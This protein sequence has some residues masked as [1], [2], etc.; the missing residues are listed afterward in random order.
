MATV[1]HLGLFPWCLY[2]NKDAVKKE[3]GLTEDNYQFNLN[4]FEGFSAPINVAVKMYW[5]VRKWKAEG[6]FDFAGPSNQVVKV[7]Y[8]YTYFREA[9][10]EK[11]LV[12]GAKQLIRQEELITYSHPDYTAPL[13]MGS[14]VFDIA[15]PQFPVALD[16]AGMPDPLNP[17]NLFVWQYA[18]FAGSEEQGISGLIDT[19][20]QL[21]VSPSNILS[22]YKLKAFE[23]TYEIPVFKITSLDSSLTVTAL[24]Y[25]PYD[26]EDGGGPI[27]D[28]LTGKQIRAFPS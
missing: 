27:Y 3:F 8:T 26:P 6:S 7:D 14:A 13:F 12:C 4:F 28:K 9:V 2:P 20:T 17:K 23:K 11:D 21:P 22:H 5:I 25:W 19:R 24:E 16:R 18:V 1:R 10:T 15:I